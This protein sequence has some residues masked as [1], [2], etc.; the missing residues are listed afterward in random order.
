MTCLV[1][2]Q[3][4]ETVATQNVLGSRRLDLM[5]M[6]DWF[7]PRGMDH[8]HFLAG[9]PA[10]SFVVQKLARHF[11]GVGRLPE[12][13]RK[14]GTAEREEVDV[15]IVGGGPAGLTV[16]GEIASHDRAM[17]VLLVDDGVARGGSLWARGSEIPD[18]P[19]V[20]IYERT[21]ALGIYEG[22]ALLA[23]G[24]QA[25]VVRPRALVLAT[26]THDGVLPFPG[27]DLPGVM[28]ARAGARLARHGIV[29]GRRVAVMGDGPYADAF[30]RATKGRVEP[31]MVRA[32]ATVAVEGTLRVS[33]IAVKETTG[34]SRPP[35]PR[36]QRRRKNAWRQYDV[37]AVLVETPGPPAF[38]LAE[39]AGAQVAFAP[40][41][42]GYFPIVDGTGRAQKGVWC[43]GEVAGTGSDLTAIR[44]QAAVVARDVLASLST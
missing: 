36:A 28:S 24:N 33:S 27:N 35:A 21:T 32:T 26:G 20:R 15:L 12:Q 2:C 9:L 19:N 37:D 29:L 22:E 10:A 18:P 43:A 42:G 34:R 13:V 3:G 39:Q 25:V 8:H 44:A 17:A 6:T 31:I 38:E 30:L 7:F 16:A 1:S 11:A 14:Q 5:Q 23:R 40:P 41:R 4:G